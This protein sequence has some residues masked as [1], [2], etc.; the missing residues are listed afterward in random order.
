M[1]KS[2]EQFLLIR[3]NYWNRFLKMFTNPGNMRFIFVIR[4]NH[5]ESGQ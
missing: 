2:A 3:L 4:I 5:R 1:Y